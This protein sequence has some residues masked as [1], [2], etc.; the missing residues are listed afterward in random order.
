MYNRL[1]M[2]DLTCP[3]FCTKAVRE[4][5][6]NIKARQLAD[7]RANV[8]E[9]LDGSRLF[10]EMAQIDAFEERISKLIDGMSCDAD[11]NSPMPPDD[12]RSPN[13]AELDQDQDMTSKS[14]TG[15]GQD[16]KKRR[17]ITRKNDKKKKST[18]AIN[19]SLMAQPW[20]SSLGAN[21]RKVV[22]P[23]M[24]QS[25]SVQGSSLNSAQASDEIGFVS[26]V[27]GHSLKE[28]Q[29]RPPGSKANLDSMVPSE[30][31]SPITKPYNLQCNTPKMKKATNSVSAI[32]SK[33]D[34]A[35]RS[36]WRG[37]YAS[38]STR[39][40]AAAAGT[41]SGPQQGKVQ[42]RQQQ[43][44]QDLLSNTMKSAP[45]IL[46]ATKQ[47]VHQILQLNP[48]VA[49]AVWM[50]IPSFFAA[51]LGF[52]FAGGGESLWQPNWS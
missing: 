30:F 27:L 4:D 5:L 47:V 44:L 19:A 7:Q 31:I 49:A 34:A 12:P 51:V 20:S 25:K 37:G 13:A 45:Q 32:S 46:E 22:V 15:F 29:K 52:I 43:V 39:I 35:C 10:Q 11:N 33:G 14:M 1:D 2:E 23:I 16:Q 42:A 6:H 48:K 9:N 21:N 40:N 3:E 38:I 36:Q 28:L 41:P 50:S 24:Q 8:K 18:V 26:C 17:K